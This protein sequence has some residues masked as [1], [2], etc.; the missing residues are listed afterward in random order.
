[1]W[2]KSCSDNNCISLQELFYCLFF[3]LLLLAKG[4]GLYDGQGPFKVFLVAALLCWGIK[5]ALTRWTLRE[6]ILVGLGVFLGAVC[7][8]SSGE[9]AVLVSVL[10]VAGMKEVSVKRVMKTGLVVWTVCFFAMITLSLAE[11]TEPLRLIHN[12]SGIGYVIRNSL[13]YTH[14]NV[15][16]I[17]YVILLALWFGTFQWKS[18]DVLKAVAVA[19]VGNLYIFLYSVSFTGCIIT[20]AYLILILYFGYRTK[21]TKAENGIILCLMPLCVVS[22]IVLPMTLKGRAFALAD[23]LVNTRFTLTRR[24]LLREPVTLLGTNFLMDNGS[25]DCSYIY[26]LLYYGVILFALFMIGYFFLIRHLLKT[27]RL[28][29]LAMVLGLVAAGFTEPFQFNFSFK[30]LILPLLGEYVFLLL[31]QCKWGGTWG[32]PVIDLFPVKKQIALPGWEYC[33]VKR[34]GTAAGRMMRAA[35]LLAVLAVGAVIAAKTVDVA[36]YVVA[37]KA[38]SDRVGE[39]ND[40]LIYG[41][42]EEEIRNNSLQIGALQADTPVYVF[43]GRTVEVERVRKIVTLSLLSGLVYTGLMYLA[44]MRKKRRGK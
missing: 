43:E 18:K 6:M 20:V 14:P 5:M 41:E 24:Y 7:W 34:G 38:Y 29:E 1:M 28:C 22:S 17:S 15:L 31:A 37:N 3:G 36:P 42:I 30:N 23:K 2:K 16:H 19:F 26:C 35:G 12:K 40:Y 4:I 21:R 39:K 33:P 9:K 13:G 8:R 44:A 32:D 27:E 10:V 11:V 25:I